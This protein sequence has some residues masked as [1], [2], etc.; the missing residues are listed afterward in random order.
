MADK[1]R[2]GMIVT[3]ILALLCALSIIIYFQSNG[4]YQASFFANSEL[5][6]ENDDLRNNIKQ[7]QEKLDTT[8]QKYEKEI[9][10]LKQ[11][12]EDKQKELDSSPK[13]G[14]YYIGLYKSRNLKD[15]QNDIAEEL[16]GRTDLIPQKAELGGTMRIE[17]VV[18]L[19]P[20]YAYAAYSDGHIAGH[21]LLKFYVS[22]D[23]NITWQLL[24]YAGY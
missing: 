19:S 22:K 4:K 3:V 11:Q 1:K 8:T 21:M 13:L 17:S 24:S 5:T 15:P 16:K 10:S 20:D 14:Q 9:G 12:L 6:T 2:L 23:G 18:L 7:L